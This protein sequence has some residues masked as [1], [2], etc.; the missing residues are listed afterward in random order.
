MNY[1]PRV[2]GHRISSVDIVCIQ[3][4]H[5]GESTALPLKMKAVISFETSSATQQTTRHHIPEELNP[6]RWKWIYR[7]KFHRRRWNQGI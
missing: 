5:K 4:N 2:C 3:R 6:R 7:R 1:I